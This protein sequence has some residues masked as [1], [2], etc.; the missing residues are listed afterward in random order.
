MPKKSVKVDFGKFTQ[1]AGQRVDGETILQTLR[2]HLVYA[3]RFSLDGEVTTDMSV[4]SP[5]CGTSLTNA[6]NTALEFSEKY[7][8]YGGNDSGRA[9]FVE[10]V[11]GGVG[12]LRCYSA[13]RSAIN[14]GRLT[15]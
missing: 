13:V 6:V 11:L 2:D 7:W 8:R 9:F 15:R 12:S 14:A 4:P 5:D 3:R 10:S 1:P